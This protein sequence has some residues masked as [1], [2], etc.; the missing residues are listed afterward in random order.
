MRLQ[1]Y[2]K[3]PKDSAS[4]YGLDG[5]CRRCEPLKKYNSQRKINSKIGL[6]QEMQ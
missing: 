3:M 1:K 2:V 5:V 6:R 4:A